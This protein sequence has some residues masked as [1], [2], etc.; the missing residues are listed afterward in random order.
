MATKQIR[1]YI[2]YHNLAKKERKKEPPTKHI[3]LYTYIHMNVQKK[4]KM[5]HNT[6]KIE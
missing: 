5:K 3:V 6:R 2:L 4:S 1:N